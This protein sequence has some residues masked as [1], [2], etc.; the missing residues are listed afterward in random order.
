MSD[1]GVVPEACG[2]HSRHLA[3]FVAR[4]G[5]RVFASG[6]SGAG[7]DF[8]D[9]NGSPGGTRCGCACDFLGLTGAMK[10]EI[11]RRGW[12]HNDAVEAL[13]RRAVRDGRDPLELLDRAAEARRLNG[14]SWVEAVRTIAPERGART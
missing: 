2:H 3:T 1:G 7:C 4:D 14:L 10:R 8:R 6:G 12:L 13:L 5:G 11:A 9:D